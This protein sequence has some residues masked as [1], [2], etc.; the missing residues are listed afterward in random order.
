MAVSPG[1]TLANWLGTASVSGSVGA[2]NYVIGQAG[3]EKYIGDDTLIT[4]DI[5][6]F[7]F[8]VL[9]KCADSYANTPTGSTKPAS[10]S[11]TRSIAPIAGTPGTANVSFSI[12]LKNINLVSTL[13]GYS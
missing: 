10:V 13:P 4:D 9:S 2:Q 1:Q 5:R 8:S 12:V 7:L 6:D 3:I 11:V